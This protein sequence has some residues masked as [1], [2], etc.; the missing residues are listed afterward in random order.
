MPSEHT[1]PHMKGGL[2]VPNS[3]CFWAFPKLLLHAFLCCQKTNLS[4]HMRIWIA[5]VWKRKSVHRRSSVSCVLQQQTLKSLICLST[6][7]RVPQ[8]V[9]ELLL[10]NMDE[11]KKIHRLYIQCNTR[12]FK[13]K[14][15]H[16]HSSE[17]GQGGFFQCRHPGWSPPRL[18][19]CNLSSRPPWCSC[20]TGS[21]CDH[22]YSAAKKEEN[23]N[24]DDKDKSND[25]ICNDDNDG[26]G[27]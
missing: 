23:G 10:L 27:Q 16:S 12:V 13:C 22:H 19:L 2:S 3:I 21:Y 24:V 18:Y 17:R 8:S 9:N 14:Q 1:K 5:L 15:A 4:G 7:P 11:L 6:E 25:D 20:P 26:D